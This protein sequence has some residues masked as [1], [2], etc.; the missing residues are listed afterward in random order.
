MTNPNRFESK[1]VEVSLDRMRHPIENGGNGERRIGGS[2]CT[3]EWNETS[4]RKWREPGTA[5]G[6]LAKMAET[7]SGELVGADARLAGA[8]I[9][10]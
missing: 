8:P 9:R 3:I 5:S 7:A 4:N 10:N 2:G 6:E 1:T